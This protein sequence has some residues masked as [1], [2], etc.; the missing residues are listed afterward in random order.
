M[1]LS[2]RSAFFDLRLVNYSDIGD[3]RRSACQCE[4][5]RR[6]Q[7]TNTS[8]T[9][10]RS[11]ETQAV[12]WRERFASKGT[13]FRDTT[14]FWGGGCGQDWKFLCW[15]DSVLSCIGHAKE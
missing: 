15:G 7:N 4:D 14:Y 2:P 8:A 9:C 5:Q 1:H 6:Q 11:I 3:F 13:N 10:N 12:D